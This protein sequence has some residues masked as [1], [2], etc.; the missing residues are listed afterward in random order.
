MAQQNG[1][2]LREQILEMLL[3][4]VDEDTYPSY[5]MLDMI[6]ELL[7]PDDVPVYAEVLLRKMR[8]ETYPSIPMIAR[9]KNLT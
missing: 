8:D 5:T 2:D 6:E 4:K 3:Q 7:T 1:Y 9:L